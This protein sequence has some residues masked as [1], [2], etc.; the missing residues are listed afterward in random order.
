MTLIERLEAATGPSRELDMQICIVLNIDCQVCCDNPIVD[1]QNEI[2]SCCGNPNVEPPALT[3]SLDAALSL[4][5]DE[6][7]AFRELYEV[8]VWFATEGPIFKPTLLELR[9]RLIIAA[10]KARMK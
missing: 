6:E 2:T 7:T 3:A 4:F 9:K 10:L 8:M 1:E 5:A